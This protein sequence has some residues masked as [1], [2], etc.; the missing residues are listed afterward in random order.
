MI[1][2]DLPDSGYIDGYTKKVGRLTYVYPDQPD[3]GMSYHIPL[4]PPSWKVTLEYH[5]GMHAHPKGVSHG[6]ILVQ[7]KIYN[8][9]E[10]GVRKIVQELDP[11]LPSVIRFTAVRAL[12][13]R[14]MQ[15]VID[16][17]DEI[18][19]PAHR[20]AVD[21]YLPEPTND[22]MRWDQSRWDRAAYDAETPRPGTLIWDTG[23]W[24]ANIWYDSLPAVTWQSIIGPGTDVQISRS[25]SPVLHTAQVGTLTLNALDGLD[26]RALGMVVG[27]PVRAY[28]PTLD[29]LFTG[30][31][32]SA[33]VVP[34]PPGSEHAYTTE[35]VFADLVA[36]LAAITRYGAKAD[37]NNGIE[38]WFDRVRRV[39][40]S[41]PDAPTVI[42]DMNYTMIPPTVWETSLAA[43]LDALVATTGGYWTVT[44]DGTLTISPNPPATDN[45]VVFSDSYDTPGLYY[46]DVAIAWD[47]AT[48]VTAVESTTHAAE[49]DEN[50]EWRAAD[51]TITVEAHTASIAWTGQKL[52]VDL[53]TSLAGEAQAAAARRLL[54]AAQ[55][56]PPVKSVSLACTELTPAMA[57]DLAHL[58][59]L[60]PAT[61]HAHGETHTATI[62][63][64][65]HRITP[66]RWDIETQL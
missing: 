6:T 47:T 53:M 31:L 7:N 17:P 56:T 50:G 23:A 12:V 61:V 2:V 8:I 60:T 32:V 26:P 44:R 41:A 30:W 14:Y 21:A 4:I 29:M 43:H 54:S 11:S 24:D 37:T 66:H 25:V 33:R 62:S 52:T 10:G 57:A 20:I 3:A 40:E 1:T 22:A 15:L 63:A 58:D 35:L 38:T 48:L 27:T 36:P 34:N 64:I 42:A 65:T 16:V 51:R 45:P 13:L 46:T 28:T 18:A 5:V 55:D 19:A 59:P 39:L 49:Q 9:S